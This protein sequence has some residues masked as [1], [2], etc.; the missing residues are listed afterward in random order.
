MEQLVHLRL[1]SIYKAF[2][3]S[4]KAPK[5]HAAAAA[6]NDFS[7]HDDE[8]HPQ[9]QNYHESG[10]SIA[11]PG[12]RM[13]EYQIG[14]T[15]GGASYPENSHS[16]DYYYR[17]RGGGQHLHHNEEEKGL[18]MAAAA[19]TATLAGQLLEEKRK[20]AEAAAEALL[21]ELEE[22]EEAAKSK[23]L[24]KKKKKARQQQQH[25]A[26]NTRDVVK[27]IDMPEPQELPV[28]VDE[29]ASPQ[30]TPTN[31]KKNKGK[32]KS[33]PVEPPKHD[34][35]SD[36]VSSPIKPTRPS[37]LSPDSILGEPAAQ[38]ADP[39]EKRL[40]DCVETDDADG[41]EGILFELK[42]VP[43]RAALRKN[44][45]KALKRLRAPTSDR[46]EPT[47]EASSAPLHTPYTNES[48]ELLRIVSDK[49]LAGKQPTTSRAECVMQIAP[50][51]V[52]WVIGK[53]G[54]RIRDLM[55]E[56]GARIW[57]DQEKAQPEDPRNVYI[58][59]DRKAV[60]LAI[61]MV[62]DIVSRVP[63]E[64]A[65]KY[66]PEE[67]KKPASAIEN[68]QEAVGRTSPGAAPEPHCLH[69]RE[70]S[71]SLRRGEIL[72][73]STLTEPWSFLNSTGT[74]EKFE[75]VMTCEARFVPL[76]IGKRGW[77]IK[78][79][80]DKSGA[81]VDIDQT[82][83]PRQIRISG[84]K[85]SVDRAIP[86]VRD[87]LN[88]PHAQPQ[89]GAPD[90]ADQLLGLE[91]VWH[92]VDESPAVALAAERQRTP[93]PYSYITTG[94]AKSAISA[95]SS[96]SSTPEPSVVPQKIVPHH[97][98]PGP[99]M[100][101]PDYH[102][103]PN[104]QFRPQ[105]PPGVHYL[106]QELPPRGTPRVVDAGVYGN[107]SFIGMQPAPGIGI[108]PHPSIYSQG[109]PPSFLPAGQGHGFGMGAGMI[110]PHREISNFHPTNGSTP[111][112]SGILSASA[113]AGGF[114]PP[115]GNLLGSWNQGQASVATSSLPPGIMTRPLGGFSDGPT[116]AVGGAARG[117][118]L[119]TSISSSLQMGS[120][121][122]DSIFIERMF[123]QRSKTSTFGDTSGGNRDSS[124][125]LL[126]GLNNL[127]LGGTLTG[128]PEGGGLW[129]HPSLPSWNA[130]AGIASS[131]LE[132][133]SSSTNPTVNP[134]QANQPVWGSDGD[135]E[136][137]PLQSRFLWG[138]TYT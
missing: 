73:S 24:K 107:G 86:M 16:Y 66:A 25:E 130:G 87:V 108:P 18:L 59:G 9:H 71:A 81:R 74:P 29:E 61:Y 13:E 36:G 64:G 117:S 62:R 92:Q 124:E 7:H 42:G 138:S 70:T 112:G 33:T 19:A 106:P 133:T 134:T 68:P 63:I 96:L 102:I 76:L 88:Y 60:D 129:G 39:F 37:R 49:I 28:V 32:K 52:G 89:N 67:I 82:M 125:L 44:A 69:A 132:S 40:C 4:S 30:R 136:Q 111:L 122:D 85:S 114:D 119:P 51:V 80:Q 103:P 110:P 14:A 100:T 5:D 131:M 123:G 38:E 104:S 11:E 23:T 78:D 12:Q 10:P 95:S 79:I 137:R 34:A 1:K 75:H 41:I 83:T 48:V 121:Q 94:D 8:N 43:G 46:I 27:E 20:E 118:L 6:S 116:G 98:G 54:Q 101:P 135:T 50:V 15:R 93:P 91:A 17:R 128:P 56:S 58:S 126:P 45:K 2:K 105:M 84:S 115:S 21:A 55:E 120:L 97:F 57:I 47:T 90:E 113:I 127:H 35:L 99:M 65:E 26:N 53:G 109:Q 22:E 72:T 77:A 31:V 3:Q